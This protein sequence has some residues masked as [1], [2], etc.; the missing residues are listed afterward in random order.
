M[1]QLTVDMPVKDLAIWLGKYAGV[2]L[3]CA[4]KIEEYAACALAKTAHSSTSQLGKHIHETARTKD[5]LDR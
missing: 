1:S 5:R 2:T 4:A 3:T